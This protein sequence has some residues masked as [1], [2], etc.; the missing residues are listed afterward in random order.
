MIDKVSRGNILMRVAV[1]EDRRC[2]RTEKE[3]I[4]MSGC[5]EVVLFICCSIFVIVPILVIYHLGYVR[6]GHYLQLFYP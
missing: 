3:E 6:I 1:N 5:L 4:Q 2:V